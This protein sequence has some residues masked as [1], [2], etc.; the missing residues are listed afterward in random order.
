[1]KN[2]VKPTAEEIAEMADRGENINQYFSGKGKM[3]HHTQ[4]VNVDFSVSIALDRL[5]EP[6]VTPDSVSSSR[7]EEE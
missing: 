1:M 6:I 5:N 4:R 2:L 7:R 3:K